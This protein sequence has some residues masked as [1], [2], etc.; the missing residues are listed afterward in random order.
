MGLQGGIKLR[1]FYSNCFENTS[2]ALQNCLGVKND[3]GLSL[4]IGAIIV[5][6]QSNFT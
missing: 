1:A 5:P 3:Q 6:I 4:K 2:K